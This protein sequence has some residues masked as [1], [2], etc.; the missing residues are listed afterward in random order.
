MRHLHIT[1]PRA[2]QAAACTLEMMLMKVRTYQRLPRLIS[3]IFEGRKTWPHLCW[4]ALS[5]A[6]FN[7]PPVWSLVEE[8]RQRPSLHT[9][10]VFKKIINKLYFKPLQDYLLESYFIH[11]DTRAQKTGTVQDIFLTL[12]DT[13]WN[14]LH[15][16]WT[17]NDLQGENW[18]PCESAKNYSSSRA[19][20]HLFQ[21]QI[22]P[23]DE[24]SCCD[25]STLASGYHFCGARSYCT[26]TKGRRF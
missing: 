19:T 6:N 13:T 17:R 16:S 12:K 1:K 8:L 9:D 10:V 3:D 20:W 18:R 23:K 2:P 22:N 7:V 21:K 15:L 26:W 4:R 25:A 5:W 14:C 24:Y 11:N